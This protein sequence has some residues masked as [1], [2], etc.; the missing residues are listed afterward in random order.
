MEVHLQIT[1]ALLAQYRERFSRAKPLSNRRESIVSAV[2][3]CQKN[4]ARYEEVSKA[5]GVPKWVIAAVHCLEASFDFGS[6]LHNGDPLT[7][8]TKLVPAGRPKAPPANGKVYTWEESAIDALEYDGARSIPTWE[9]GRAL[10]WLEGYNGWG[11]QTGAGRATTPANTS[12]YLWS[13]TSEYQSGKYV[14]DGRFDPS[15][16]SQQVGAVALLL[17]LLERGLVTRAELGLETEADSPTWWELHRESDAQSTLVGY[18]GA[19]PVLVVSNITDVADLS[20][21]LGKYPGA[22]TFRVAPAGKE[23]PD[24]KQQSSQP[25][26]PAPPAPP[27]PKKGGEARL[28]WTGEEYTSGSWGGLKK[29]LLEVGPHKFLVSSGAR[30]AQVLRR[31]EDPRS[32]PKNMEPLPQGRYRIKPISWAGGK[33]NYTKNHPTPGIGPVWIPLDAEFSDDRGAF[34]FHLDSN[35][36]PSPGSAG[37]VVFPS[38]EELKLFVAALREFDPAVLVVDWRL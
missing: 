4:W 9:V 2:N 28:T 37:C 17:G 1:P 34:G 19:K 30:Y 3:K 27:A 14:A 33:D 26:P 7:A 16:V 23:I 25:V 8:R 22:R 18:A 12:P 11:Y 15:A 21:I 13:F 6:H 10:A 29:L 5:T 35:I 24:L 38:I 36:G 20:Y 32:V 31:P